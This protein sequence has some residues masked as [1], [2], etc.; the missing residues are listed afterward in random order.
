MEKEVGL[1]RFSK[2]SNSKILRL[3]FGL[4]LSGLTLYLSF[5]NVQISEALQAIYRTNLLFIMLAFLAVCA[6][7]LLKVI[8]W[9]LILQKSEKKI[10]FSVLL[11]PF[12][13]AKMLNL[14]I[15]ASL[16]EMTRIFAFR[17]EKEPPGSAYI[18]GT[19]AIEKWLDYLSFTVLLLA[20]FF[21]L[22]LPDWIGKSGY[23]FVLITLLITL[24]SLAIIYRRDWMIS[25]LE[26]ILR[27][28]PE[29]IA[30]YINQHLISGLSSFDSLSDGFY[31]FK[32]CLLSIFI[33]VMSALINQCML[34][35]FA[36][37]LPF[38]TAILLMIALQVGISL[39]S[40][41]ASIGIFEY[42]CILTLGFFGIEES[43]ALSFGV[44][45]HVIAFLPIIIGGLI[46]FWIM[47]LR[48]S[49]YLEISE[50]NVEK[51]SGEP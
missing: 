17:D 28:L 42:I 21:S 4:F 20:L 29:R 34:M 31:T 24:I 49:H 16:G 12:M 33:W 30:T 13:V 51:F 46:S 10:S 45:L 38:T 48:K 2:L 26:K 5:K 8:R 1:L 50:A 39:P 18:V 7:L 35:A 25:N 15:P 44:L 22:Q 3:F 9:N 11:M 41:P 47:Q 23:L 6:S 37:Q 32:L 14:F 36:I 19:L 27:Y 43:I 40:M